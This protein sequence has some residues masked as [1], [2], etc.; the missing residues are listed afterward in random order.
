MQKLSSYVKSLLRLADWSR[1]KSVITTSRAFGGFAYHTVANEQII[2]GVQD[3]VDARQSQ[4]VVGE[5]D[6]CPERL[7]TARNI[8]GVGANYSH[9]DLASIGNQNF[10]KHVEHEVLSHE[11]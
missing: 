8:R 9:C 3:F 1:S 4:R 10:L 2:F 7:V 11:Y 6:P 5:R